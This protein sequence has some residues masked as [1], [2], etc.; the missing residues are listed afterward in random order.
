MITQMSKIE[1]AERLVQAKQYPEAREICERLRRAG[2]IDHRVEFLLGSIAL[3]TNDFQS[4]LA[5]FSD[6]AKR[7][8]NHS[9]VLNNLGAA[10]QHTGGDLDEAQRLM[11]RA[12][13]IDPR[14]VPALTSLGELY[15]QRNRYD[16][17]GRIYQRLVDTAPQ[18]AQGYFGLGLCALAINDYK[19]AEEWLEKAETRAPRQPEIVANLLQATTQNHRHDNAIRIARKI[20]STPE[21]E[22]KIITA[23]AILKRY[24][25]WDEAAKLFPTAIE[26]LLKSDTRPESFAA[27]ALEILSSDQ[28]SHTTLKQLHANCGD[29]IRLRNRGFAREANTKAFAPARR[30]RIGYLSGDFRNH[31]AAL[32]IRGVINHHDPSRFEIFLYSN[33]P[34]SS[35][36]ETTGKFF[37]VAEHFVHCHAMD[38]GELA[39]RIAQDGIHVLVD[40]S[41]FTQ[42]SRMPALTLKPAPV[43][44]TYIGY[45][46]TYGL[47]EVDYIISGSELTGT[48]HD[49]AFIEAPLELPGLYAVSPSPTVVQRAA[50]LPL[51]SNGFVTFGSLINPYKINRS[52]VAL[53]SRV[54]F[55]IPSSRI[56]LNHPVYSCEATRA[57]MT[58]AFLE[59]GIDAARVTVT[60]ERAADN[61]SHFLLY[62][63]IDIVL[64]AT[65]MTGGAGTSDALTVGVPVISRLGTVFH[66]RLSAAAIVANVPDPSAFIAEDDQGF[67]DR[68]L[69]LAGQPAKLAELRQTIRHNIL[70]GANARPEA[71]TRELEALFIKAWDT[72]FPD[73]PI[74]NLCSGELETESIELPPFSYVFSAR[75]N[76]LYRF[77]A[78]E[79]GVWFEPECNLVSRHADAFGNI[80]DISDDP[81]LVTMPIAANLS[82]EQSITCLRLTPTGRELTQK[83]AA[84][85]R[86]ASRYRVLDRPDALSGSPVLIRVSAERNDANASLLR[87]VLSRAA[88]LPLILLLSLDGP[89]GPDTGAVDHA[90]ELGYLPYRLHLGCDLLVPVETRD[91]ADGFV[92]NVF[93]IVPQA[94]QLLEEHGL[95]CAAPT[96]PASIPPGGKDDWAS[97]ATATAA[98]HEETRTRSEWEGVYLSALTAYAHAHNTEKPS[99]AG[100]R[101]GWFNLA[102]QLIQQLVAVEPTV[103]RLFSAIRL[104]YEAGR[105]EDAL[106]MARGLADELRG[107]QGK[108]LREPF[109]MPNAA[110]DGMQPDNEEAVWSQSLALVAVEKMRSWSSFF[111]ASQSTSLWRELAA[112]PWWEAESTR[113]L[114]LLGQLWADK[115]PTENHKA[116]E[117]PKNS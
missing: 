94:I 22:A 79:A 31:V 64:D 60:A 39:K 30:M 19:T 53:W 47:P 102:D 80:W 69:S 83:N 62:D 46:A 13:E 8:P 96:P 90:C 112:Y 58:Q 91:I 34:I 23:W 55:E 107:R 29:G 89:D 33:A 27:S 16:D 116:P 68:A 84:H 36:D 77:V 51:A 97:V 20:A 117:S 114:A 26:Q 105:R 40:M 72:K 93:C 71:F 4:A 78:R 48:D 17:A 106:T 98:A 81:G 42:H 87:Q 113:M 63:N 5:V 75:R 111:T 100:E 76:D 7:F 41:G 38:D 85:N 56:Y 25:L 49:S 88:T 67:V 9:G 24:C 110:F 45:P 99:S 86:L 35:R 82:A 18:N 32:F 12:I 104:A 28:V 6:L 15:Y 103:P 108:V 3:L 95:L 65:P 37:R 54:L 10:L 115:Q 73:T 57:S 2:K 59:E 43:Q 11:E 44:M 1:Q 52:T 66:E 61:G 109:L 14:N 70:F 21:L 74:N 92:R 101:L 50:R